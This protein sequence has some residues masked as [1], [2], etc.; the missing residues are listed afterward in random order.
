LEELPK[1][2]QGLETLCGQCAGLIRRD[3]LRWGNGQAKVGH[4]LAPADFN[5][6][7]NLLA[8]SKHWEQNSTSIG[9]RCLI[10][11]TMTATEALKGMDDTFLILAVSPPLLQTRD[12]S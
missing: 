1:F 6:R 3:Q 5:S 10:L 2:W 11:A 7:L 12:S 4:Q 9:G 8:A